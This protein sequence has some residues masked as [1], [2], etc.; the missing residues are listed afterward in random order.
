MKHRIIL[1]TV[2][3]ALLAMFGGLLHSAP[4]DAVSSAT[5][6]ARREAQEAQKLNGNYIFCVNAAESKY[7]IAD[8]DIRENLTDF[9]SGK[10][11][12]LDTG[13][14]ETLYL[15]VSETDYALLRYAKKLCSRF[16]KSGADIKL[17]EYSSTMLYSR[18]AS[19]RYQMFLASEDTFDAKTRG[20][21]DFITL[22]S[23][24]M[25]QEE[26]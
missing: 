25:E 10:T 7:G 5:P 19:G 11:D 4:V 3:I 1:T 26:A 22:N 12:S 15:Y 17:R 16:E 24:E 2:T 18:V 23:K 20:K 9:V 8:A 21:S 14:K 13:S 6:R